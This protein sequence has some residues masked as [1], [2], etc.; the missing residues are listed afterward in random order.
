MRE[1]H[2]RLLDGA[3]AEALRI[4]VAPVAAGG[5]AERLLL[6]EIDLV[7][8][9]PERAL[10]R[11]AA[12][13]PASAAAPVSRLVAGRAEEM[14]GDL[15]AAALHYRAAVTT[16]PAAAAR[17]RELEL[18]ALTTLEGR[19]DQAIAAGRIERARADLATLESWRPG[20]PSTLR[21]SA[22]YAAAA[23]NGERELAA[24]RELSARADESFAEQIRRGSLE[25][26]LGD[27]AAGLAL[28]ERLAAERGDDPAVRGAWLAARFRFRL[29]NS[30]EPVRKSA[31]STQLTRADF[32]RLLYWLVP[33]VRASRAVAPQIATDVLDH[34]ARDEVVRVV[35]LGLMALEPSLRRFEPERPLTRLDAFRALLRI[36]DSELGEGA[37]TRIERTGALCARA[38]AAGWVSEAAECLPA[39]AVSGAEATRWIRQVVEPGAREDAG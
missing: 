4:E 8:G 38:A 13:P 21:R 11:I 30:P 20:E 22:R 15:V 31:R 1:L 16:Q 10:D 23:G 37:A 28:L 33:E 6:A 14:R 32:A 34:P 2:A 36:A 25:V 27:A 35:N 29:V 9:H 5:P 19:I 3:D 39:A 17:Y 12:L 26:Q 7:A 24:L 18:E